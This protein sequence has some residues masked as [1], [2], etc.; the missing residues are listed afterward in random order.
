[1]NITDAVDVVR[2]TLREVAPEADLAALAADAPLRESLDLDSLDFLQ[3]I[4]LL[5]QRTG[6]RIDE[7]DYPE[8][9]SLSRAASFLAAHQPA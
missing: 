2:R 6:V 4:E 8:L 9:T 1:M 7:D 3:F 5:T